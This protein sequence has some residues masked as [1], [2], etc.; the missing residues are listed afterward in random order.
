MRRLAVGAGGLGVSS[1]ALPERAARAA[2]PTRRG[3]SLEAIS[4]VPAPGQVA[5]ISGPGTDAPG[6]L[7]QVMYSTAAGPG[8][9]NGNNYFAPWCSG[10]YAPDDGPLG[11]MVFCNGGGADYWGNE[12]YR[13]A[14]D[15]RTW[16][17]VSERSTGLNG[18]TGAPEDDPNFD[19]QWGEHISPGGK[20]PPQ[21]GVPHSYDQ[22]EYLPP[23]LGGGPRGSFMFITRT[24]VY[25]HRR[26]RH[27]HLFDLDSLRWRRGLAQPGIIRIGEVESPSWCFD[28]KRNR[29]WGIDGSESG[30]FITR[31][32]S[33]V[34]DPNTRL[35][36][37]QTVPIPEF[38]TPSNY[39]VSRYWPRGDLLLVAGMSA[40]RKAFA[41][42]ACSLEENR[43]SGFVV[44]PLAGNA[45]PPPGAG[46]GLAY[47]DDL[48]CFFVRTAA[49]HRQKIWKV[50]PPKSNFLASPW[51]V[52]EIVMQGATVA[53]NDNGQGLWK[54]LMYAPPMK[55]LLWVDD[56]R[57]PVYAY[58]PLGS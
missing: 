45:L 33:V 51:Q 3:R 48:D 40:D 58:R 43:A 28:A 39:P 26:F 2:T 23:H 9:G 20:P 41:L 50:V 25:R 57:G 17:R 29:Y 55:C 35:G 53:P 42:W 22:M 52:E 32:H 19:A 8:S 37:A 34:F 54:R 14:L 16:S 44:V 47:C 5:P 36:V 49:G 12:V 24:I 56:T 27:P 10:V 13:F 4:F 31:L 7:F 1:L 30:I 6:T 18:K 11:S 46:Y 21:P 38:L 15:T